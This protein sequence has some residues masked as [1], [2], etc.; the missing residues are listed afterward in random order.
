MFLLL[1]LL[2]RLCKWNVNEIAMLGCI[3][4]NFLLAVGVCVC[5][6]VCVQVA[7]HSCM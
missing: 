7:A 6:C 3:N 2:F 5:M 4:F 1:L